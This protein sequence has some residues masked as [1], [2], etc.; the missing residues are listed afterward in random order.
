[1]SDILLNI[2]Y[3]AVG[4]LITLGAEKD[5]FGY[6]FLPCSLIFASIGEMQHSFSMEHAVFHLSDIS[7][8]SG[9]FVAAHPLHPF[10]KD[11]TMRGNEMACLTYYL[12]SILLYLYYNISRVL[13]NWHEHISKR[14][15]ITLLFW[16]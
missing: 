12:V 4:I 2:K 7:S 16:Y 6:S 14:K 10:N 3:M 13:Q 8:V 5:L 15:I 9:D 11:N 1:M